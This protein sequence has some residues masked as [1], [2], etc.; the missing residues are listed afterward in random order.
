ML[1]AQPRPERLK[2]RVWHAIAALHSAF[3]DKRLLDRIKR[4]VIGQSFYGRGRLLVG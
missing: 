1:M 4:V 2:N 3:L